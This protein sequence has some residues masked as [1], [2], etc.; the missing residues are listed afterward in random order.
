MQVHRDAT[1]TG[2]GRADVGSS[3]GYR[4]PGGRVRRGL[5]TVVVL[6]IAAVVVLRAAGDGGRATD[7]AARD[8]DD[9]VA[10][11]SVA[12]AGVPAD[13]QPAV[14]ASITDG[15]TLQVDVDGRV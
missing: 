10:R 6:A 8:A 3:D 4:R 12:G 5:W 7:V 13:A 15:D 1:R 2:R 9:P 14:V 11:A